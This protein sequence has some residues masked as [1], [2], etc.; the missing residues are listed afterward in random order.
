MG[1]EKELYIRQDDY[2]EVFN[3]KF[4]KNL[5]LI[6]TSWKI[7]VYESDNIEWALKFTYEEISNSE[8]TYSVFILD[9]VNEEFKKN[10]C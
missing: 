4:N 3:L 7:D 2:F 5:E 8:S 10:K 1:K 6:N 9:K